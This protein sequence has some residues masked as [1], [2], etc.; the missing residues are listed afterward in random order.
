MKN[1]YFF[2][3]FISVIVNFT[4]CSLIV[5]ED[6]FDYKNKNLSIETRVDDLLNRMTLEEK[7]ELL[8]G[9]DFWLFEGIERLGVPKIQVTDC[10]HGVTIVFDENGNWSGNATSFPTA[11]GQAATWNINLIKK[12]GAAIARETK[13][14]G[15]SILLAP[16]VNLKRSPLNGRNYETFSEDPHHSG[17]MAA[18]FIKGVQSEGVGSVV[19]GATANN[20][21][22]NQHHLNIIMD[23]RTLQEIYLPSFR[24][25]IEKAQPW[26]VMTAYNGLNNSRT[27]ENNHLLNDIIKKEWNFKGFIVSDWRAVKSSTSLLTGLDMEMPGPGKFMVKDSVLAHLKKGSLSQE[28]LDDKVKRILRAHIKTGLV[29]KNPLTGEYEINSVRHKSLAIKVAEESIV[30]LKNE[31]ETLPLNKSLKKIAVIGPNVLE[32]RLGGGGSASV[33]PF[34][35][36]SPLE[37][38]Q[39]LYGNDIAFSYAEGCG[40]NGQYQIIGKEFVESIIDD[41]KINGFKASY[42]NNRNLEGEPVMQTMDSNIDF[43]WGW[44]SPKQG[45]DKREYSVRWTGKIYPPV[46]GKY[47]LGVSVAH[48]RYKLFINNTLQMG[49]WDGGSQE[50]FEASF[51]TISEYLDL[52]LKKDVPLNVRLE[53]NKTS[54]KNFIRLEWKTPEGINLMKEAI[55][56]ASE[57]D[58]TVIFAGLSNFFEGGN[59]DR[60]HLNLPDAQN[61]LIHEI[62]KASNRT[63]VVLI[64]GSAITMPWLSEVESVLEAYYPGQEGGNAIAKVL[65]GA[66]NPSGKLPET[67][68]KNLTDIPSFKDRFNANKNDLEYTEG[69][70]MGYRHYEKNDILPLFPFG[71]GLSY[72]S[73][74]YKNLKVIESLDTMKIKLTINNT[75]SYGGAEVVQLYISPKNPK[76]HRPKKELKAFEKVFLKPLE[77]KEV[78]F[79]ITD[80]DLTYYSNKKNKW[81]LENGEYEFQIGSSSADIRLINSIYKK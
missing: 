14:T 3:V 38:L 19:K 75:G 22:T 39:N 13:S 15:S 48:G 35:S 67:F 18:A 46:S 64:N 73:F 2:I 30:M 66:I 16:M 47:K 29:D 24:I 23:E 44:A 49:N 53:F 8:T 51:T 72:T 54:N 60:K 25:S 17:E 71:H 36:I 56:L 11:V 9:A 65:F 21:Q 20:Q 57:S 62:A 45:V 27:S 10:G 78:E 61:V 68:P 4:S 1:K 26:G 55:K 76:E 81:V 69:I 34:Y 80:S 32:A 43:S 31:G 52:E 79:I 50:N 42:F 12:V 40:M 28:V 37:G 41:T 58:V 33:T 77:S 70:Y 59:N 6:T 74:K 63:I 5:K 7:A